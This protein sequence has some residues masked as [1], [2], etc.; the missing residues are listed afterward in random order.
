MTV[1]PGGWGKN[2]LLVWRRTLT[3][4]TSCRSASCAASVNVARTVPPS[5]YALASTILTGGFV[6]R[7][8]GRTRRQ[9]AYERERQTVR[10]D[11]GRAQQAPA[12]RDDLWLGAHGGGP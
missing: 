4:S 11:R 8:R 6:G 3:I 2:G 12:A 7:R 1:T 5:A 10:G 9:P